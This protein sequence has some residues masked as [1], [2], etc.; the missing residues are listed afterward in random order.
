MAC[1]NGKDIHMLKPL[2]HDRFSV[3][4][5]LLRQSHDSRLDRYWRPVRMSSLY[6][7]CDAADVRARHGSARNDVEVVLP[8]CVISDGKWPG[9]QYIHPGTNDV[10]LQDSRAS[11]AQP[12]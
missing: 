12:S 2:V 10:R 7:S 3:D 5:Q 4:V 11:Q 8:F 6:Y 9:H 1:S